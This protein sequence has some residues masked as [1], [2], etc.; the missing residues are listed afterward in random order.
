MR[1][2]AAVYAAMLAADVLTTLVGFAIG[3]YEGNPLGF[4]P[5]L[6]AKVALLVPLLLM[7]RA[8]SPDWRIRAAIPGAIALAAPV[9]WNAAQLASIA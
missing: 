4:A 1:S 9:A 3:G 8:S 7:V 5:A 2:I 6:T